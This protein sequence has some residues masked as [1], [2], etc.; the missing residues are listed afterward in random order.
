M[1]ITQHDKPSAI[2]TAALTF[3]VTIEHDEMPAFQRM[4]RKLELQSNESVVEYFFQ[5]ILEDTENKQ[6][7]AVELAVDKGLSLERAMLF[8]NYMIERDWDVSSHQA[9][10]LMWIERFKNHT[11]WERSDSKGQAILRRLAPD[12]Y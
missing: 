10:V 4:K 12:Q 7:Q 5:H 9:Y 3:T 11:E 6:F 2:D 1:Y 8:A